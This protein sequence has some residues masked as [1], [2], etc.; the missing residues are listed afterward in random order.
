V[1]ESGKSRHP[2]SFHIQVNLSGLYF[3]SSQYRKAFDAAKRAREIDPERKEGHAAMLRFLGTG[4]RIQLTESE[5]L[6]AQESIEKGAG[7]VKIDMPVSA[8]GHIDL[9]AMMALLKEQ[10]EQVEAQMKVYREKRLPLTVLSRLLGRELVDTWFG[11]THSTQHRLYCAIGTADEQEAEQALVNKAEE[12]VI[13]ATALIGLQSVGHL[14]LLPK[15]FKHI[16]VATSTYEKFLEEL[17]HLEAFAVSSGTI[18]LS[19]GR[20]QM[21][22]TGEVYH[23]AKL[24][25]LKPIVAFLESDSVSIEGMD[26]I[27]W[28]AWQQLAKLEA[29][30]EWILA[31]AFLAKSRNCAYYCDEFVMRAIAAQRDKVA[32]FS[33]QAMMRSAASRGV[34]SNAEHHV[35]I[36]R[37]V[38]FNYDFISLSLDIIMSHLRA[39]K[40]AKTELIT[41]TFRQLEAGNYTDEHSIRIIGGLAANLW[42]EVDD[43]NMTSREDW[44]G[45]CVSSLNAAKVRSVALIQFIGA[46]IPPL[47]E[48]PEAISGLLLHLS[49]HS[50]F[51]AQE[52]ELVAG[53]S[54][55]IYEVVPAETKT[56]TPRTRAAWEKLLHWK[57][58]KQ[59]F[60]RR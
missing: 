17:R 34:I 57:K 21:T 41:K 53:M 47:I 2:N 45:C 24:D 30:A 14:N 9:T 56:L 13:D 20:L 15:M 40:F 19:E 43:S 18:R 25:I 6:L 59:L 51:S 36:M 12:I 44:I 32:G 26:E 39:T 1:L 5:K 8:D 31:P 3:V 38:G 23:Q 46:L 42:F 22:E 27:A 58:Q 29:F 55:R 33:I 49:Q 10:D 54:D 50:G 48:F 37:L 28:A 52:R 4:D 60:F 11:I 7:I 35:A 16:C